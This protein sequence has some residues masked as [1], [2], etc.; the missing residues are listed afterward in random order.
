LSQQP[1][2]NDFAYQKALDV[3]DLDP[4]NVEFLKLYGLLSI[5]M[6]LDEFAYA[7]VPKIEI[8][9]TALVAA[10]FKKVLD[11][12]LKAKNYPTVTT[13]IP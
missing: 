4:G 2:L 3:S 7:I 9:T 12:E 5:R 13:T 8:L 1:G 10:D 11:A 6:G